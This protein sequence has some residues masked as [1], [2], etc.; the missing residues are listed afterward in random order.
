MVLL[1]LVV[2]EVGVELQV[3]S[4]VA[5]SLKKLHWLL[6]C[7]LREIMEGAPMTIGAY[8]V[9]GLKAISQACIDGDWRNAWTLTGLEDPGRARRFAGTAAE[10]E[11][12][13]GVNRTLAD[14]SKTKARALT[15]QEPLDYHL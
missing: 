7:V 11:M 14:L 13:V 2:V 10:M 8:T 5:L 4:Q 3:Q 15:D 12:T 1:L 9:Q 6:L